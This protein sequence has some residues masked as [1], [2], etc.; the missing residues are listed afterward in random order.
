MEA[1]FA[2]D[3]ADDSDPELGGATFSNFNVDAVEYQVF[4]QVLGTTQVMPVLP[5]GQRPSGSSNLV[6]DTVNFPDGTTDML[7]IPV[8]TSIASILARYPLPNLPTGSFGANTYATAS[9]VTTNADQ[10]SLRI[11]H[12]LSAKN[13]FFARFTM[14]S[15]SGPTTN[16]DQSA[17]DPAFA[18]EYL[19]RRRNVVGTLTTTLTLKL[20]LTSSLSITRS[21][22]GF[23]TL[24]V[25]DPAVKFEG[26]HFPRTDPSFAVFS[27]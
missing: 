9:K 15:L 16:P 11:D 10:F 19:D 18:V 2:K 27:D 26:E 24:D 23:P 17:I 12:K 22:P 13:Q 5:A 7:D 1:T 8:T 14:C 25:S 20:A 6:Y 3:G 4:G 21:T